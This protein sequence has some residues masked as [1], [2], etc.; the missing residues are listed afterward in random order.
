MNEPVAAGDEAPAIS[1]GLLALLVCPV[2][3][4]PFELQGE[5][6]VCTRCGRIYPIENGIPNLLVDDAR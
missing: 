6:L 1:A 5:T 3:R 4:A 2:D